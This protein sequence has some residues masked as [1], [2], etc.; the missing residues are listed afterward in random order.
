[1]VARPLHGMAGLLGK[2]RGKG[3]VGIK[4]RK[5]NRKER[6]ERVDYGCASV[7][8]DKRYRARTET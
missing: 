2:E 1:M 7:K 5:E 3:E 4:R 8:S 6:L